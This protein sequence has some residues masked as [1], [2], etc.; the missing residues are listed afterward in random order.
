MEKYD[1]LEKVYSDVENKKIKAGDIVEINTPIDKNAM[2]LKG[3]Y[4]ISIT[5]GRVGLERTSADDETILSVGEENQLKQRAEECDRCDSLI[6]YIDP[7]KWDGEDFCSKCG[8]S[9]AIIKKSW[10]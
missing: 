7:D 3:E 1:S 10:N 8:K 6:N 9:L 2:V 4:K 5:N